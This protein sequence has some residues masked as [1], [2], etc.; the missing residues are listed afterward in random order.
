MWA[1]P[2]AIYGATHK[3]RYSAQARALEELYPG[4]KFTRRSDGSISLRQ[5]ELDAYTLT[6]GAPNKA[7]AKRNWRPDLSVLDKVG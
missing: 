1:T 5:E 7:K 6:A 3:T 4:I 2:E